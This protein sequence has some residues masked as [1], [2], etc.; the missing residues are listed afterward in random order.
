MRRS[1]WIVLLTAG[2]LL[3]IT[4]VLYSLT[5]AERAPAMSQAV[6]AQLVDT[7][8]R[9]VERNDLNTFFNLFTEDAKVLGRSREDA[10]AEIG[11]AMTE[12]RGNFTLNIRN[13]EVRPEGRSAQLTFTMDVGQKDERMDVVYYPDLLMRARLE[14]V[15]FPRWWGLFES[16]RWMVTELESDPAILPK[17]DA[18]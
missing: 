6:A 15:R 7:G 12:L 9:A 17:P 3:L 8:R 18:P 5:Y 1:S 13:L 4:T 10:R 2:I 16:E 11:K 14:K